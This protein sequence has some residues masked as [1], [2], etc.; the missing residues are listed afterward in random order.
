MITRLNACWCPVCCDL[1]LSS[2]FSHI[3]CHPYSFWLGV[4]VLPPVLV[5]FSVV[6]AG[7]V[8]LSR[9][10]FRQPLPLLSLL[11]ALS[12]C[13]SGTSLPVIT[14]LGACWCLVCCDLS[15]S[16]F[17]HF[18]WWIVFFCMLPGCVWHEFSLFTGLLSCTS[19][20]CIRAAL[21]KY[22][23]DALLRSLEALRRRLA[24]SSHCRRVALPH[25]MAM[26]VHDT[27]IELSICMFLLRR[28]LVPLPRLGVVLLHAM[29]FIV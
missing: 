21:C 7:V 8:V 1:S 20:R 23:V 19:A 3:F 22:Q 27:Q 25:A 17:S 10:L 14:R 15:F 16:S 6:G 13:P 9:P 28:L 5:V 11:S 2:Y 12:L 29:A 24:V 4:V 18:F 26:L